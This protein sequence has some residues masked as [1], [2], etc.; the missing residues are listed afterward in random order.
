MGLTGKTVIVTG[1]GSNIG[2]GIVLAFA[3]EAAKVVNAEIDEEQGQRVVDEA[4][5]LGG[6][7][8]LIKTDVTDWNS[9]QAMVSQTLERYGQIDVLVNNAGVNNDSFFHKSS[10]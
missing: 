7:A 5:G 9:V 6:E 2:R 3:R 4:H 1:G 8:I 10:A